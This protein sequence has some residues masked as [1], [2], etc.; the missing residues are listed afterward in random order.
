MDISET[1]TTS[2][3]VQSIIIITLLVITNLYKEY[4]ND[5]PFD[6]AHCYLL[7][8]VPAPILTISGSPRNTSFFQGLDLT[9]ICSI[10]LAEAVDTPVTV[11]GTWSR[12]GTELLNG[13]EDGRI[14]LSNILVEIPPYQTT[15][16]LNPVN[17]TDAGMYEC[18]ATVIPQNTTFTAGSTVSISR[19]ISIFGKKQSFLTYN[20][21]TDHTFRL[22]NARGSSHHY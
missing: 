10:T 20:T 1:N 3:S 9:F 11:Q 17:I 18:T 2:V 8:V 22:P 16:R 21:I 4:Y 15:L 5:C 14:T 12:N 19:N 7:S 13:D 6:H